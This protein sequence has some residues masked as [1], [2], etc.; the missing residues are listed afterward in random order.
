MYYTSINNAVLW[1]SHSCNRCARCVL[2]CWLFRVLARIFHDINRAADHMV[3]FC[4]NTSS[5][6]P[7]IHITL[8]T[9]TVVSKNV[10]P[11][12]CTITDDVSM[13]FHATCFSLGKQWAQRPTFR[14]D[15]LEN[16]V[17]ACWKRFKLSGPVHTIQLPNVKTM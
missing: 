12:I 10:Y 6:Q 14:G 16:V 15:E 5:P 7:S 17:F 4:V 2:G 3:F 11:F 13:T 1:I 8:G 9:D